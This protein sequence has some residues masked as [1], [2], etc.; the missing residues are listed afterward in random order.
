MDM[1]PHKTN[2]RNTGT[3]RLPFGWHS[4]FWQLLCDE[5]HPSTQDCI[6]LVREMQC[7]GL[8]ASERILI[9]VREKLV[10]RL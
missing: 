1:P 8:R 3:L 9:A 6:L 5:A 2:W 10:S 4:G 7:F